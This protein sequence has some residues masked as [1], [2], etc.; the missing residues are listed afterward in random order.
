MKQ[1]VLLMLS[2]LL[3]LSLGA[4]KST[5]RAY[6]RG[7]YETAVINSIDRLRRA[8]ENKK[9]R[10]TLK[11][12]YPTMVTYFQ[13]QIAIAKQS[14]N[15]FRW[16]EVMLHY[17]VLNRAYDEIRKAPA[18]MAVIPAPQSFI[19]D[20]EIARSKAAD[21]RYAMGTQRL[22]FAQDGNREAAKEA[23]EHFTRTIQLRP[24]Y[25]DA[26]D[27]SFE[28]LELATVY[29]QIEPI[30]MHSRALEISNEFFE[31]QLVEEFARGQISPF[32]RFVFPT[33]GRGRYANRRPDQIIRMS[34]DDFVVGQAYVRE[35]VLQRRRDSVVVG[36]VALKNDSTGYVY[37]TVQAE[38]H[39]FSKIISSSGTL[40]VRIID[41]RSG[42]VLSQRKFPGTFEWVDYWGYFNGDKRALQEEDQAFLAK[43]RESPSPPPQQLFIEFTKPIYGQTTNFVREF[44]RN[45]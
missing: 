26:E 10:H 41:A 30:P 2:A 32:I 18:A 39:Q 33:E 22:S 9:A 25:K 37:G 13:E 40:D 5:K 24:G 8:P 4:C 15:P 36:T 27:L 3:L 43:K 14:G 21:A 28:A 17:E 42:A 45:Y 35:K 29:V 23:Y 16:E 44:Y 6:E 11:L 38:M 20:Y 1:L 19:G 7:D 34:F 12:A 31:S